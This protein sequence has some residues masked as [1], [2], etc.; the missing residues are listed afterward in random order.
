M[1]VKEQ[2]KIILR[3]KELPFFEEEQLDFYLSQNHNRLGP[4]AYQCLLVKAEETTLGLSGLTTADTSRY[5]RR[6]AVKYRPNHSGILRGGV[7]S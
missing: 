7:G 3:E 4:T 5:F 1:T 6:L 2:L